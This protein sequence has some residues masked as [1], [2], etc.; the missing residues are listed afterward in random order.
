MIDNFFN[1]IRKNRYV[2]LILLPFF[3]AGLISQVSLTAIIG[4]VMVQL[5]VLLIPG[6]L[7][8]SFLPYSENNR[9]SSLFTAYAVGF[10]VFVI[11]YALFLVLG[12]QRYII[13]YGIVIG[14]SS[15]FLLT[16]L[17]LPHTPLSAYRS[18]Y[19]I[20]SIILYVVLLIG[21][22]MFQIPHLS[23][24]LVGSWEAHPDDT[25]MLKG[26]IASVQSYP[27]QDLSVEGAGFKWH[28]F[29]LFAVAG[30][31]YMT[32][33][34]CFTLYFAFSYVWNA[35]LLV[36]GAYFIS[37]IILQQQ[38]YRILCMVMLLFTS[39][40]EGITYVQYLTHFYGCTLGCAQ[41]TA[42]MM[43]C[44]GFMW[45]AMKRELNP[46]F[47]S[48]SLLFF[49]LT[50]GSKTPHG[51]VAIVSLFALLLFCRTTK[52]KWMQRVTYMIII[53][54]LFLI[55]SALFA[56]T[57]AG[58]ESFHNGSSL[59]LKFDTFTTTALGKAIFPFLKGIITMPIA[60]IVT[61]IVNYFC[62][63]LVVSVYF[64]VCTFYWLR[65]KHFFNGYILALVG[66]SA[67]GLIL[68]AS[69][70]VPGFSQ[71]YFAESAMVFAILF[72][73]YMFEQ[74]PA[75]PCYLGTRV[76]SVLLVIS[77]VSPWVTAYNSFRLE[78]RYYFDRDK[79]TSSNSWG[80]T[81]QEF[82]GLKW[83]KEH[84]PSGDMLCTNKMLADE[85]GDRA[86]V[87]TCFTEHQMWVE[88]YLYG[89]YRSVSEIKNRLALSESY[90]T[91]PTELNKEQIKKEG[92]SYSVHYKSINDLT[93]LH[94]DPVFE[95][96]AIA[97][98]R[99]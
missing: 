8:C 54:V 76:F 98:V 58:L 16:I 14:L 5:F 69:I 44:I 73:C 85:N 38:R 26:C 27:V 3:I 36:G 31:H 77:L 66:P 4:I 22:V 39:G 93:S 13:Y 92:V 51:A 40:L 50:M 43:Y 55:I 2:L 65:Y 84:I 52:F 9:L 83:A 67:A 53:T 48:F 91:S 94:G 45:I 99:L 23:A 88:G 28:M 78:K 60:A 32:G 56:I 17:K 97:I 71:S 68:F 96:A 33:L 57:P 41:A 35:I 90:Y 24:D 89:S 74:L 42:A 7:L 59:Y 12:I 86:Y 72:V 87:T 75:L 80:V 19:W 29:S 81:A 10:A 25:F 30:M 49:A 64:L 95:N 70:Y 63:N 37:Q 82:E 62:M 6:L 34:D 18:D 21:C 1:S 47:S 20:I 79:V 61:A 11:V 15:I 46:V